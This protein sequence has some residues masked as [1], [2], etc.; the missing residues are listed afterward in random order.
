MDGGSGCCGH[1]VDWATSLRGRLGVAF[2]DN[3]TLLYGTGGVAWANIDYSDD[4]FAGYSKTH[5]GWVIGGGLEHMLTQSLSARVE[6]LYYDF[7]DD[8]APAGALGAGPT[9][10]DPTMQTVRFGLNLKF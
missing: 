1:S 5:F 7:K 8:T 9:K 6:Y 2:Y 10:V 4:T 3:R